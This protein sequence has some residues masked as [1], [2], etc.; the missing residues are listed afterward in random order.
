MGPGWLPALCPPPHHSAVGAL[1][2]PG[3]DPL[4][5]TNLLSSSLALGQTLVGTIP[6]WAPRGQR[7]GRGELCPSP[8]GSGPGRGASVQPP[9]FVLP[10]PLRNVS[11]EAHQLG[12][13][14]Q[15]TE[16]AVSCHPSPLKPP[17]SAW[18]GWGQA[19]AM[20][21]R[22]NVLRG[23]RAEGSP[24][25]TSPRD[26][27]LFSTSLPEAWAGRKEGFPGSGTDI[28]ASSAL[29]CLVPSCSHCLAERLERILKNTKTSRQ[30]K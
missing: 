30:L 24:G 18:G 29:A 7:A 26:T 6:W 22:P 12:G 8:L 10:C 5:H 17:L 2:Q 15:F 20:S 11:S 9:P 27:W 16:G 13:Q 19:G 28:G 23:G 14:L 1:F 4:P 3:G 21:Q 25:R